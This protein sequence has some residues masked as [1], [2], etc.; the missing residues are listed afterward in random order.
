MRTIRTKIYKF[1]ELTEKA[2]EQAIENCRPKE[3]FWAEENKQSMEAFADCF[4]VHVTSWAYGDYRSGVDFNHSL[5][6]GRE[7]M[8][9]H[10]LATYFW[11]N[12]KESIYKPKQYWICEGRKNTVGVNSKHRE[13]KIFLYDELACPFTGYYM[14]NVILGPIFEFMRKP[15]NRTFEDV[16]GDCFAA[17]VKGCND[18]IEYSNSDKA[19]IEEIENQ[20]REFYAN[21]KEHY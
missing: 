16:I 18:E 6:E 11:N 2:K 13:S 10:R 19:I 3:I 17:W 4:N 15:D 20:D 12:Y 14:D 8:I 21:G 1:Y 5:D 7:N 9:G